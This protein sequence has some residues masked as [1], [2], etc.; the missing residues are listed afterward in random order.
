MT[1]HGNPRPARLSPRRQQPPVPQQPTVPQPPSP[2]PQS[3]HLP[4][5][6]GDR[7]GLPGPNP[8]LNLVVPAL[9]FSHEVGPQT[10]TGNISHTTRDPFPHSLLRGRLVTAPVFPSRCRTLSKIGGPSVSPPRPP[11]VRSGD[12]MPVQPWAGS[13]RGH[14][15]PSCPNWTV[16]S[17]IVAKCKICRISEK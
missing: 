7:C 2:P 11:G 10:G 4:W 13:V 5:G 15:G 17:Y 9:P 3:I 8:L 16:W 1:P 12:K 14:T 6:V